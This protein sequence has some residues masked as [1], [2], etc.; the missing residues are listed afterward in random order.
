M[1][2]PEP[3]KR[4]NFA[5]FEPVPLR[6][7]DN[8]IYGHVN[9]AVH[10]QLFDTAVNGWLLKNELLNLRGGATVFLVVATACDYFAEIVFPSHIEA[11]LR[12]ERL[13]SSS[14]TY[15]IGLFDQSDIAVAEGRF[16]HV[17]VD[18]GTRRPVELS[19]ATRN[20]LS[21]LEVSH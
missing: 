5:A 21:R 19:E 4:E 7:A 14:V 1:S 20:V 16:V 15:R 13:G 6:W 9:N 17:Q 10:Y 8:D 12:V 11:G 3:L 18:R 2:R